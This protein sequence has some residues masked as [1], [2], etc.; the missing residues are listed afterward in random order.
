MQTTVISG[1]RAAVLQVILD[2]ADKQICPLPP[3]FH[4]IRSSA[5]AM[6]VVPVNA[7]PFIFVTPNTVHTFEAKAGSG[8][9]MLRQRMLAE[10]FFDDLVFNKLRN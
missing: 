4:N 3:Q 1:S 7:N 9:D 8:T 5:K 2:N 10:V 6:L